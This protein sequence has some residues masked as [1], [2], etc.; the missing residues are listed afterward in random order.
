MRRRRDPLY[1]G[2]T[3]DQNCR[4]PARD[5]QDDPFVSRRNRDGVNYIALAA[6]EGH[7]N[8]IQFLHNKGGDLDNVDRRGRTPLMEATLWGWLKVVKRTA[9]RGAGVSPGLTRISLGSGLWPRKPLMTM[10]TPLRCYG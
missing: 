2:G 1:D 7:D 4:V 8:M 6:V 3:A 5:V 9:L 10:K